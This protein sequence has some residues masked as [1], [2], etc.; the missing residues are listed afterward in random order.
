MASAE[1]LEALI[2][3]EANLK[4]QYEKKLTAE[5]YK[6][7]AHLETQTKLQAK[8]VEQAGEITKLKSGGGDLKRME[9]EN[10]EM[11]SRVAN[12]KNEFE[13]QRNKAKTAQKELI[14]LKSEIKELKQ[15]DAKKLKKNL[16]ETKKKLEEQRTANGLLSAS[17][18][19][20]KQESFE[21]QNS[22]EKLEQELEELKPAET[23]ETEETDAKVEAEIEVEAEAEAEE[24]AKA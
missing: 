2:N 15:L 13:A 5:K 7:E 24:T 19:K 17:N 8:I 12:I 23:E 9:Q 4:D 22:I 1:Q 20:H 3:L 18:K 6:V 16:V 14:A 10:R 21:H 11:S